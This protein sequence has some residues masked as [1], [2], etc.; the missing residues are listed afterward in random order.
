M[1]VITNIHQA[2]GV[3][4]DLTTA[5]KRGEDKGIR[6]AT[7]QARKGVREAMS[8]RGEE[9]TPEGRLGLRTG[10]TRNRLRSAYFRD[11]DDE[12]T[13]R[14][15]I[16]PPRAHIARFHELGTRSH[17]KRGGPLPARRFMQRTYE[18]TKAAIPGIVND[19]VALEIRRFTT[20]Y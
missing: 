19:A 7:K 20:G 17:G 2:A 4:S 5:I 10:E 18:R 1:D 14:V 11:R 15:Y 12:L 9:R 16:S 13:G 6:E 8:F 3:I